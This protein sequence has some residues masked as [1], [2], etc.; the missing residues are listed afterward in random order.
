MQLRLHQHILITVSKKICLFV[1][2]TPNGTF[3]VQQSPKCFTL[4][5]QM[6]VESFGLVRQLP[7]D[8]RQA[9]RAHTPNTGT[10]W[11]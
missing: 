7:G 10:A 2:S 8:Q 6:S 1:R 9:V 5:A 11:A 3:P 4:C